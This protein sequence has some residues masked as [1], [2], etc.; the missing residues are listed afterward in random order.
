MKRKPLGGRKPARDRSQVDRLREGL[1]RVVLG[2]ADGFV[3]EENRRLV[4]PGGAG[5]RTLNMAIAHRQPDAGLIHHT[6]QGSIYRS[7]DYRQ[8][9]ESCGIRASMREQKSA[10]DKAPAERFFSTLKSEL[11]HHIDFKTRD[12]ARS[13]AL[14][15]LS[16]FTA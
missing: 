2:D 13:A 6:D 5:N 3:F 10:Y 12:E 14:V 7:T 11:I 15:T 16:F 1:K 4:G 8:R 9:M